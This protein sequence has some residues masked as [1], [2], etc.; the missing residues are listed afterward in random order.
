MEIDTIIFNIKEMLIERGDNIDEFEEHEKDIERED[1]SNDSRILEFH[2]SHTT[3]IFCMTKKLRKTILD[4][5]KGYSDNIG[6]FI[7]PMPNPE[8]VL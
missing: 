4:E 8:V 5:L 6:K 2:T 7:I 1:F 3:V